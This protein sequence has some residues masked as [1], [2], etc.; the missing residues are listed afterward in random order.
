MRSIAFAGSLVACSITTSLA[1]AI[2]GGVEDRNMFHAVAVGIGSEEQRD[3]LCSGTL[4][5]PNVV[6]TVRHCVNEVVLSDARC[7]ARFDS[8]SSGRQLWVSAAAQA[9]AASESW[10][11][12]ERFVVPNR[13]DM[14]GADIALLVLAEAVPGAAP[15]EPVLTERGFTNA[16]GPRKFS[17]AGFGAVDGTGAGRG[18]RRVRS[19][20]PI[21]CVPGDATFACGGELGY[22]AASEFTSGAG[23]C[24]GDSGAG[25]LDA[26]DPGKVFGLLSRGNM[27]G[28]SCSEGV[29]ER[30]DP[31]AWF[32]AA[33]V[34]DATPRNEKAP[35]WATALFPKAA[36]AGEL[37]RDAR[38]CSE[39]ACVSLDGE[40][41]FV[42]A[43]SCAAHADCKS[44]F[45]CEGGFCATG[46]AL[47]DESVGCALVPL[48]TRR[49]GGTRGHADVAIAIA[50]S[51]V[52]V[53]RRLRGK[54]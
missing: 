14:C 3:V 26:R 13:S 27:G 5:S 10:I 15:A 36:S 23:P 45:R 54:R 4:I 38:D 24:S 11:R 17:L 7:S 16:T 21:R 8:A 40:R 31:W 52:I 34:I 12:V 29:F 28:G 37:C 46:A 42:C 33:T 51:L 32:V 6:L 19:D 1:G 41:S 35:S 44:G 9:L 20:I 53:A 47:P 48:T 22:I 30:I 2:E 43:T 49:A 50:A 25:A 18:T 39:G